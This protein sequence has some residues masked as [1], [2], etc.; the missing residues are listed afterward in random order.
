MLSAELARKRGD[1]KAEL[2]ALEKAAL[3]AETTNPEDNFALG[4][5]YARLGAAGRDEAR[6][7]LTMFWKRICR[8]SAAARFEKECSTANALM[9]KL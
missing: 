7:H 9:Q 5:A 2:A 6:K 1:K 3:Y 8:G 4:S